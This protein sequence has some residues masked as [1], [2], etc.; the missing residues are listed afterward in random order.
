MNDDKPDPNSDSPRPAEVREET[1]SVSSLIFQSAEALG[2]ATLGL[3]TL[4]IGASQL[5][6]A[7]G[8]GDSGGEAAPGDTP[9]NPAEPKSGD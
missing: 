9:T 6:K 8:G 2:E 7:F 3:G 1:R 5:K 4:A